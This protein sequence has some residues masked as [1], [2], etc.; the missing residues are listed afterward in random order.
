M[1][2][3]ADFLTYLNL[4]PRAFLFANCVDSNKFLP[5]CEKFSL[6]FFWTTFIKSCLELHILVEFIYDI[7]WAC[8]NGEV[9]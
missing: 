5:I 6:D 8:L 9:Y 2:G 7:K 1:G 3:S 4:Y